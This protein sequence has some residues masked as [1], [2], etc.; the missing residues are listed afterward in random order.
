MKVIK[1]GRKQKGWAK[2]YECTG[3]GNHGGGCGAILLV[4]EGDLFQTSRS[5]YTGDT[6]YYVTFRCACCGSS[7]DITDS[8]FS[9]YD[10]PKERT[11]D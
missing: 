10:L 11:E 9:G 5:D 8:P 3:A 4:E 7:T 1:E 2:E 6:D